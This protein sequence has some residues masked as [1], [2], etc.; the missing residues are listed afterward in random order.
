MAYLVWLLYGL[1]ITFILIHKLGANLINIDKNWIFRFRSMSA[2][3][4]KEL[5]Y[6]ELY[7]S[8]P[9]ELNDPLDLGAELTVTSGSNYVYE[10]FISAAF[11]AINIPRSDN[12]SKK[13]LDFSRTV[14]R[15]CANETRNINIFFTK[16]NKIWLNQQ[17]NEA[18]LDPNKY[19]RFYSSLVNILANLFPDNLQSISFSDDCRNPLLWSL[20]SNKHSGFSIILSPTDKKIRL[21]EYMGT[22]Y[23][24]HEFYEVKYGI[25][26]SVDL[27]LMFN[28]NKEFDYRN[29]YSKYFPSLSE[30][31]LLTKNSNWYKENELR[32]HLGVNT[33]FSH[34][35]A[36]AKR[37]TSVER[38]HYYDPEQFV[39]IIYG[40]AMPS[41]D[42]EEINKVLK[43]K[44]QNCHF[45]EAVPQGN[46]IVVCYLGSSAYF[47]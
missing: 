45:Y 6:N 20:Y 30:K 13:E 39:G 36:E 8:Y 46:E 11:K 25:D 15:E 22:E 35:E 4:L 1:D 28:E 18:E 23:K 10:Y 41:K 38:I 12:I 34:I 7:F 2:L 33:C 5:M 29:L 42:R 3:S 16:E 40:Y 19:E 17:Y 27:S 14:A 31:A 47:D 9:D 24:E 26:I 43:L 44:K 32:I 37:K 21:K